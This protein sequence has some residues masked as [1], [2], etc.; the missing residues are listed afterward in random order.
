MVDIEKE[1]VIWCSGVGDAYVNAE[2]EHKV[3]FVG[4][5]VLMIEDW[6]EKK[7]G[8]KRTVTRF[9]GGIDEVV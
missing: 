1:Q 8:K 3:L 4:S 7:V 6:A 2:S 5:F 9:L